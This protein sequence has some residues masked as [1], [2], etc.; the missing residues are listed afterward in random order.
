MVGLWLVAGGGGAGM[1]GCE[2]RGRDRSARGSCA[3]GSWGDP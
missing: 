2:F 1:A 3:V